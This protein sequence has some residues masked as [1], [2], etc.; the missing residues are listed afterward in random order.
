MLSKG[1]IWL[2][3]QIPEESD[4]LGKLMGRT[5][6]IFNGINKN[7]MIWNFSLLF[8]GSKTEN[9]GNIKKYFLLEKLK[10]LNLWK[11]SKLFFVIGKNS[12]KSSIIWKSF[13]LQRKY[14]LWK[15]KTKAQKIYQKWVNTFVNQLK[16]LLILF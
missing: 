13:I 16:F 6:R 2:H 4:K 10:H 7:I 15:L 9:L 3:R 8:L 5:K 11:F 14:L 1:L 12:L